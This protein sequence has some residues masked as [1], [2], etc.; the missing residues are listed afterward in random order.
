MHFFLFSVEPIIYNCRKTKEW[1]KILNSYFILF[2]VSNTTSEDESLV[3]WKSLHSFVMTSHLWFGSVRLNVW[4]IRHSLILRGCIRAS[5]KSQRSLRYRTKGW[6]QEPSRFYYLF[7]IFF[8]TYFL[9]NFRYLLIQN[10]YLHQLE[11]M[12]VKHYVIVY[13]I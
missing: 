2:F 11:Y 3:W 5:R 10:P 12:N 6:N 4:L 8:A 9:N 7:I 13:N 1:L